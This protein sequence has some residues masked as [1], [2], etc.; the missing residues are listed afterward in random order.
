VTQPA[1]KRTY[2]VQDLEEFR[3]R[4]DQLRAELAPPTQVGTYLAY[5]DGACFGNPS[6][7]G[8][9]GA[10]VSALPDGAH[11]D[12]WGHLSSTSNNRAEALAVLGALEWVPS[13]STLT[14]RSDSE[15]TVRILEG[16]YKVKANTDIWALIRT[17]KD[18][19]Q[20]ILILEWVRGHVG[21]PGN[22]LA[23]RLSKL[24]ALN[25][26]IEALEA[27]ERAEPPRPE[28]PPELVGLVPQG[29]WERD[30][31]SSVAQQ[32]RR[33]RA[34]SEKQQAIIDRI[35]VRPSR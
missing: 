3:A 23:D 26:R 18:E 4:L 30:F 28:V 15:L 19:K 33:G 13:G 29:D 35:R 27:S 17:T 7:P 16:R 8:G 21:D 32:L 12:L 9:W 20:L 22:E 11:W 1:P 6:G 5:T 34:L 25:G 24:G 14:I 31:L 10:A 2:G